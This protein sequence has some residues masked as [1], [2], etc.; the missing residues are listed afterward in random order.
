ME[1]DAQTDGTDGWK[2][3]AEDAVSLILQHSWER[4]VQVKGPYQPE[5]KAYMAL[6]VTV[7][8]AVKAFIALDESFQN[9]LV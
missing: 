8:E 1:R 4:T 7:S 3:T 6:A 9:V 5:H 2:T